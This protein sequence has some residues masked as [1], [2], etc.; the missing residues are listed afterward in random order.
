MSATV[1][2]LPDREIDMIDMD[3]VYGYLGGLNAFVRAYGRKDAVSYMGDGSDPDRTKVRSTS[4]ES[5]FVF[6]S[7]LLNP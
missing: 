2:N 7:K 1:K 6:R 4:E 5:K 3:D